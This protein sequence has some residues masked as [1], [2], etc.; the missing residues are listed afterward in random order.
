M[1]IELE[2][3]NKR[4]KNVV[5]E[6]QKRYNL[7]NRK[8]PVNPPKKAKE[9]APYASQKKVDPP[10]GTPVKKDASTK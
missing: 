7:R 5:L 2:E 9:D 10:K 8:V 1:Y 3:Y 4:Y 6:V